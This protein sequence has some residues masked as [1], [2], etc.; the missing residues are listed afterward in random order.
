MKSDEARKGLRHI[1]A[2]GKDNLPSVLSGFTPVLSVTP[3]CRISK[4]PHIYHW[5]GR[6]RRG[7]NHLWKGIRPVCGLGESHP[8]G[9]EL[10]STWH[11]SG[12]CETTQQ[13][14]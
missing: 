5:E 7:R 2:A 9:A 12:T 13:R 14:C 4:R 6:E 11:V 10:E 1:G 3:E 8:E